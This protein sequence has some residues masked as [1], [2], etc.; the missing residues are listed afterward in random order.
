MLIRKVPSPNVYCSK[1][2]IATVSVIKRRLWFQKTS[3]WIMT[4]KVRTIANGKVRGY[5]LTWKSLSSVGFPNFSSWSFPRPLSL[6]NTPNSW[7]SSSL[8]F[9]DVWSMLSSLL[10]G[11]VLFQQ[12]LI[13]NLMNS[14][15]FSQLSLVIQHAKS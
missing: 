3:I 7:S 11:F 4:M 13:F 14:P 12:S 1:D 2:N 8:T 9:D 6:Q 15:F 5:F 10:F